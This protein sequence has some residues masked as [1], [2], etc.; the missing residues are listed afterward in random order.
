MGGGMNVG[1]ASSTGSPDDCSLTL[2]DSTLSAI[3]PSAG[4]AARTTTAGNGQGGGLSVLAGSSASISSTAIVFNAA[5]GGAAG[6]G[7]TSGQGKG[8]GLYIDT[9][10]DVTLSK[11]TEVIF[12]FASTSDDNIFGVYTT[13]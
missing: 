7:G 13:S 4:P 3:R 11:S 8:G 10:A 1:R 5:P 12:N 2:T 6:K 9:T